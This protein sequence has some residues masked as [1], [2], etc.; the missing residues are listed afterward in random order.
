M[1]WSD[2]GLVLGVRRHGE[3]SAIVELM[4]RQHGRHL[5]LVRGGRSRKMRPILQAG[6]LV[7]VVW[8]ARLDEHL[9]YYQ[10]EPENLRAA[11]LMMSK[12]SLYA[13]QI[14]TSY[15]RLLPERESYSH[16]YEAANIILD[17]ATSTKIVAYFIIRFELALLEELGFGLSLDKC[18]LS[19]STNEL[20]WV[21][22]K[23]G[24]AVSAIKGAPWAAKLLPLPQFMVHIASG[25]YSSELPVNA[26]PNELKQAM[27]LTAHFLQRNIY[28][29]RA[30]KPS[31]E[32]GKLELE[33]TIL[34]PH[35]FQT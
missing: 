28:R 3:T 5:G 29:P 1:E 16:M 23:S 31:D 30:I 19:G 33:L 6:N 4:T 12:T 11:T 13:V 15:L 17:H 18:V 2:Q 14:L 8:R 35:K 10:I 27:A 34:P 22:P 7:N 20:I 21:S 26:S 9:G 25:Q 32:R 24:C